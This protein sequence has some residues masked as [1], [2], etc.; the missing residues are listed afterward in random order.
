MWSMQP[1]N[2]GVVGCAVVVTSEVVSVVAAFGVVVSVVFEVVAVGEDV[3]VVVVV[4][5]TT[6]V[7]V[8]SMVKEV[9]V[10]VASLV[11]V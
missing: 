10:G 9:R 11:F 6:D 8:V 7:V 2:S 5:E 4:S 3:S 1:V